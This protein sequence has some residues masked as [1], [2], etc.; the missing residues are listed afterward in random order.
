MCVANLES[1]NVHRGRLIAREILAKD[2]HLIL[3]MVGG[4]RWDRRESV[5]TVVTQP[6]TRSHK[7]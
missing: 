6:C 2:L 4:T 3:S 5:R 1:R 7:G